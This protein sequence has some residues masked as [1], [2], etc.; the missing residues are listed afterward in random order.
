MNEELLAEAEAF[1]ATV[2]QARLVPME[3]KRGVELVERLAKV[4]Q[5][6]SEPSRTQFETWYADQQAMSYPNP[7]F[8]ERYQKDG[9]M[10][11]QGDYH[12]N[13]IEAAWQGFIFGCKT[14]NSA[15]TPES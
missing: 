13:R 15:S 12:N 6:E 7:G 3:L 2:R 4:I 11:R 1:I 5:T 9:F 8:F 10:V 14:R